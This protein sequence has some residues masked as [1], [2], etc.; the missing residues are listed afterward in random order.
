[1]YISKIT[2]EN[3]KGFG[4]I[5]S[6]EFNKGINFFVGNNNCGKST[7]FEA[8]EFIKTL[9]KRT[10]DDFIT[11]N[12]TGDVSV[13]I[14]FRGNVEEVINNSEQLKKQYGSYIDDD[15]EK[16]ITVQRSSK[17]EKVIQG[18]KEKTLGLSNVRI[19]DPK[20][21]NFK[22]PTGVDSTIGALFEAQFVW[23][24]TNPGDIADFG[25]TKI[26]GRLLQRSTGDFFKS[27]QWSNFEK[28]HK[29][30]FVEGKDSLS[31]KVKPLAA[32]LQKIMTEQYGETEVRFHFTLPDVASFLKTGS[33][34]LSDDGIDTASTAKGT[35]MQRALALSL[36]QVYAD[37]ST[38][39]EDEEKASKPLLFFIDEPE[40]FLHP[41][42]QYKL[43][44]ALEK[45]S[46]D[47]QIFVTTHSP[48]LL[49]KYSAA[50]HALFIFS[51]NKGSHVQPSTSLSLFGAMSPTWGEINY[52]AFNVVS[53]EFHNELYG[54]IQDK[55][56]LEDEKNYYPKEFDNYLV[57][58]GAVKT[59]PYIQ[60]KADGSELTYN[61]T[62]HTYIRNVIHH[63]ENTKNARFSHDELGDSI[64]AMISLI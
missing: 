47:S 54:Y 36:I 17:A 53:E 49:K 3:F 15:G 41:T 4:G 57:S 33:I 61:A 29:N 27:D 37:V 31:V 52:S 23:A 51:K 9:N 38:M 1:M 10:K 50:S 7:V 48:Y 45:I 35:G 43:L 14:E 12:T 2:L 26:C 6:I 39:L 25:A 63:P 5:H 18:K 24:D 21:G 30:T 8:V 60:L 42:A 34:S 58:K 19:R 22:N 55:A 16:F 28:V 59:K 32:K 46:I 20:D 62:P 64:K 11:K 13:T 44:D 56:I 40:T